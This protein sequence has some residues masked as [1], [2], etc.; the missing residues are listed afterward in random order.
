MARRRRPL[1]LVA[2]PAPR[3]LL[4]SL[5]LAPLV[6]FETADA[7]TC[8]VSRPYYATNI[9]SNGNPQGSSKRTGVKPVT[10]IPDPTKGA[11]GLANE[12][13]TQHPAVAKAVC[14]VTYKHGDKIPATA[15]WSCSEK[16]S[17]ADASCQTVTGAQLLL[18]FVPIAKTTSGWQFG[19][20]NGLQQEYSKCFGYS[21]EQ[22][23][24][25]S[26]AV[27]DAANKQVGAR[28]LCGERAQPAPRA[29][30]A[31]HARRPPTLSFR[32]HPQRWP[33][34]NAGHQ[35]DHR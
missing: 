6:A 18:G 20:Y 21:N 17:A 2:A 35:F 11:G 15:K 13:K 19:I 31:F 24:M 28:R 16:T 27:A 26:A 30:R 22:V 10:T 8:S 4:L 9:G 1:S 5:V 33:V 23:C 14:G 25:Y 34:P 3:W 12:A 7:A 32:R 29:P